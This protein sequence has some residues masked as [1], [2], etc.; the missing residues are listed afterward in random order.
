MDQSGI[1]EQQNNLSNNTENS[2]PKSVFFKTKW[3]KVFL[4][5]IIFLLLFGTLNYFNILSISDVFPNQL[6]WLPRQKTNLASQGEA[7]R[8]Y[9]ICHRRSGSATTVAFYCL[10]KADVSI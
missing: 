1:P 2:F 5:A 10:L 3:F 4:I 7:L 8:G 9:N 6:D